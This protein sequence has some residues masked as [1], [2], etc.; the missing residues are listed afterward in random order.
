MRWSA[1]RA[2]AAGFSVALFILI[3]VGI[4]SYRNTV[5]IQEATAFEQHTREVLDDLRELRAALIDIETAGRGYALTG[6]RLFLGPYRAAVPRAQNVMNKLETEVRNPEFKRVIFELRSLVVEKISIT[7]AQIRARD[8]KGV[9]PQEILRLLVDG[10]RVMDHIREVVGRMQVREF[11]LLQDRTLAT[12]ERQ[13]QASVILQ[14]G[15][16]SAVL[17]LALAMYV[18]FKDLR[19][20]KRIEAALVQTTTLQNAILDG[21]GSSIIAAD[22][23]GNITSFNRAAENMLGYRAEQVVG[24]CTPI[25]LHD[26]DE[27]RARAEALSAELGAPVEPGFEAFIAKARLGGVDQNEWTYLRKDGTR[28][29]VLLS[30]TALRDRFGIVSG[31]LGIATDITELKAAQESL[32]HAEARFRALIQGSNDIV[33]MLA[34]SG[35]MMYVSPAVESTIGYQPREIS[36]KNVFDFIHP[37]DFPLAQEAFGNTLSTP[38]MAVPLQLR[39]RGPSGEFRWVE[40]LANNLVNDPDLRAVVINARDI[41]ERRELERRSAL[42]SSVTAVLA[43]SQNLSEAMSRILSAI[44]AQMGY[45]LGE[46][47]RVD[48]EAGNLALIEHWNSSAIS[49][50][51]AREFSVGFRLGPGQ[52]LPGTVWQAGDVVLIPDLKKAGSF[53]RTAKSLALGLTC[54]FGIPIPFGDEIIAVMNFAAR[55]SQVPDEGM[56]RIFRALASQIGNFMGRK[57]A[58]ESEDRLRRQT[59]LILE[60]AGEG[61]IGIDPRFRITFANDAGERILGYESGELV[62]RDVFK[63]LHPTRPDGTPLPQNET[64]I[65]EALVEGSSRA[66]AEGTFWRK[67]GSS[68]PVQYVGAPIRGSNSVTGAVI[69]F[70]DVTQR[71]EIERIKNEFIS[72]V[73]HELRTP[74]TSI[75]GALGLLAGGKLG[76]FPEK[77]QRML[78]IAVT[79]TDRLVR[80][81]ND[82]LDIERI[83]SG[84]AAMQKREVEMGDL[85]LQASDVMRPMAEKNSV[86]LEVH[87]VK[88]RVTVDPDRMIQTLTN[89]ISNAIKFSPA[90]GKVILSGRVSPETLHIEVTDQGRGI[91]ND[92]L[93]SIFERFQQVDATDSREKG[94]TGLGLAICRTIVQQHG[95][96]IW[97]ESLPGEG[98]VFHIELPFAQAATETYGPKRADGAYVLVCDDDA[99]VREVVGNLL[100][101]RGFRVK[102]VGSGA[103]AI[104]VAAAENPD[105]IVL[106]LVM[107]SMNGWQVTDALKANTATAKIP[108]VIFSV[109]RPNETANGDKAAAVAGW[110]TKPLEE[111]HLFKTLTQALQGRAGKTRVLVVEDDPDLSRVMRY[112]LERDGIEVHV[113]RSGREAIH[114]LS[115]FKPDLLVLDLVLPLGDGFSVVQWLRQSETLR[116]LPVMVYSGRDL[117]P[118]EKSKLTVGRTEFFTKGRVAPDDFEQHVLTL[119][120]QMLPAT[121]KQTT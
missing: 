96:R 14:T 56:V 115:D 114:V 57:R 88:A 82:I 9:S 10:R 8:E 116:D 46:V 106:D 60:S 95:G 38:G 4:V 28:F 119:L 101:A 58:E 107:P 49:E 121:S 80:L 23:F 65:F 48:T 15:S 110:V 47:W 77:A 21:A 30:V 112:M 36:G 76:E 16:V 27:I 61:I 6:D 53:L 45:D 72:V 68:F 70:Q 104:R 59:Q 91:P 87:P 5:Q 18:I 13:R 97:A 41:G 17:F 42:Q 31:Y 73:S 113:A 89:L 81:I 54:G 75:R 117:S 94:G 84:R 3:A 39:L 24:K 105:L 22:C 63:V 20:R 86:I 55:H 83:D 43:D 99:A 1:E 111:S 69:T 32:R 62:G 98:S 85:L 19:E 79:N 102:T 11:E 35:A 74:L 71:R 29:P 26:Q 40:I 34:P 64:P 93:E 52:G 25:V 108:I 90:G 2:I 100:E 66:Q 51:N 37:D 109:L 12:E 33:A 67:D 44:G 103:E 7:Q 92:K 50:V 118:D 78:D 120:T